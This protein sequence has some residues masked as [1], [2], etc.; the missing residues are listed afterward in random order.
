LNAEQIQLKSTTPV[1]E[2]SFEEKQAVIMSPKSGSD[3]EPVEQ[4]VEI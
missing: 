4:V 3:S 2:K 1:V